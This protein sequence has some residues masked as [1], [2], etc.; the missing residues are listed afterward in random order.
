MRN[1]RRNISPLETSALMGGGYY[2]LPLPPHTAVEKRRRI[3]FRMR[4]V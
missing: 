1:A 3:D 2:Y 4:I